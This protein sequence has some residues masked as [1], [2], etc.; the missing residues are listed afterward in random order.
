MISLYTEQHGHGPDLVLL[1]GWGLHSGIWQPVLPLLT[2]HFRITLIDL[3]GFGQSAALPYDFTTIAT[4]LLHHAPA[5]AHWLGWSLGGLFAMHIARHHPYRI[6]RLITVASNPR[7]SNNCDWQAGM[8]PDVLERFAEQLTTDYRATLRKFLALQVL[9]ESKATRV[10][11]KLTKTLEQ[12]PDPTAPVLADSLQFLLHA[13]LRAELP[14]ITNPW[15]HVYGA[16]DSLVP[17]RAATAVLQWAPQSQHHIMDDAAH[18]PFLSH[19]TEFAN[20][21]SSFCL[22]YE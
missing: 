21:V 17:K 2:P 5:H 19:P 16:L 14:H 13:D 10:L 12:A 7:F 20:L 4:Q 11:Q 15:L 8:N 18:A 3:P 22:H 9:K 1:H 6:D